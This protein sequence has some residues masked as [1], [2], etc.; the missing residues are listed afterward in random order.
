MSV[1][2]PLCHGLTLIRRNGIG[3]LESPLL[4]STTSASLMILNRRDGLAHIPGLRR[5]QARAHLGARDEK[6]LASLIFATSRKW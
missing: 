2:T 5:T 1:I 4:A 6:A 3:R